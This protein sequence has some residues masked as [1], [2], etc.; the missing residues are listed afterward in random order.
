MV[1]TAREYKQFPCE[2]ERELRN[3]G[4]K[5]LVRCISHLLALEQER[6]EGFVGRE[7]ASVGRAR[8]PLRRSEGRP[9]RRQAVEVE[10]RDKMG[11]G[12]GRRQK[13]FG[14]RL[15]PQDGYGPDR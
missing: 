3:D 14:S 6:L 9:N 11:I 10:Y 13:I 7:L 2:A 8:L 1:I 5:T 4:D 15:R 12:D